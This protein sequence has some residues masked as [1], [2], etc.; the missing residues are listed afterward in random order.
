MW[1]HPPCFGHVQPM[2]SQHLKATRRITIRIIKQLFVYIISRCN[3]FLGSRRQNHSKCSKQC[4]LSLSWRQRQALWH[5]L[6]GYWPRRAVGHLG[7][8]QKSTYKASL[9]RSGLVAFPSQEKEPEQH[10]LENYFHFP[11]YK[12]RDTITTSL[13]YLPHTVLSNPYVQNLTGKIFTFRKN[14]LISLP[15]LMILYIYI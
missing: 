8:V 12:E 7:S 3:L 2:G 13:E 6:C 5:V 10:K 9:V 15:S 4:D 14:P 1:E 11:G